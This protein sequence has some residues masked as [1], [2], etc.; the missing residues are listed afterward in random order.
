M[1]YQLLVDSTSYLVTTERDGQR[2]EVLRYTFEGFDY[3]PNC[4]PVR[5]PAGD[6]LTTVRA[7]DP[8][9]ARRHVFFLKFLNGYNVGIDFYDKEWGKPVHKH[10]EPFTPDGKGIGLR[11]HIE[12]QTSEGEVLVAE[13]REITIGAITEDDAYS[14]DWRVISTAVAEEVEFERKLEWGGYAGLQTRLVRCINPQI[15]NSIG[16]TDITEDN[17]SLSEWLDYNF[18]LDGKPSRTH[19][20][21]W[22]GTTMMAHP[23]NF[24]HPSPFRGYYVKNIHSVHAPILRDGGITLKQGQSIE[25]GYRNMIYDGQVSIER[26]EGWYEDYKS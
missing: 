11:H 5:T 1:S 10:I 23:N 2:A 24:R 7:G 8:P 15:R 18:W 26:I 21:F 9:L 6:I 17:E 19:F 22:A 13:V 20:E 14:I 25:L 16:E 12:W 3:H 4:H